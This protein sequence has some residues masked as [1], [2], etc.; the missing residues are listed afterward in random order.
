MRLKTKVLA[1]ILAISC[2]AGCK[3][4]REEKIGTLFPI[5]RAYSSTVIAQ[6]KVLNAPTNWPHVP[7]SMVVSIVQRHTS[8]DDVK[9]F[10]DALYSEKNYT[11]EE[12]DY[13]AELGRDPIKAFEANKD[14]VQ[15][16]V[17]KRLEASI[18]LTNQPEL[19][20][21]AQ[22]SVDATRAEMDI[23]EKA[24]ASRS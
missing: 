6:I 12:L 15:V 11:D 16:A 5:E 13:A 1:S 23:A 3:E 20:L 17:L 9:A 14:R 19:K 7:E 21:H 22:K 8:M 24:L 2:L 4:S 18:A 10:L